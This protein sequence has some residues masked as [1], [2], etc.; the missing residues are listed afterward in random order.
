MCNIQCV[1]LVDWVFLGVLVCWHMIFLFCVFLLLM[2]VLWLLSRKKCLVLN[3]VIFL[4]ESFNSWSSCIVFVSDSETAFLCFENRFLIICFCFVM[5][6]FFRVFF[7]NVGVGNKIV[8]FDSRKA[9]MISYLSWD[10]FK[11]KQG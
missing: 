10:N 1:S 6:V 7:K 9:L 11:R 3:W 4:M 2:M 8:L 5:I